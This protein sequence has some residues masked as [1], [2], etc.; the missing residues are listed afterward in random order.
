LGYTEPANG[1][2]LQDPTFEFVL[3]GRHA[4]R[5]DFR[6]LGS[7]KQIF[8]VNEQIPGRGSERLRSVQPYL[9]EIDLTMIKF[10]ALFAIRRNTR[11][12]A[13]LA[14]CVCRPPARGQAL[15][16]PNA[17]AAI[18]PSVI[19]FFLGPPRRAEAFSVGTPLAR[20][21]CSAVTTMPTTWQNIRNR[22]WHRSASAG[23][24]P[25]RSVATRTRSGRRG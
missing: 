6:L 8:G 10:V 16:H 2:D 25:L 9:C 17:H 24:V 12:C 13:P 20:A 18:L 14:Q 4:P 3:K 22:R 11:R 1:T 15:H 19:G 23:S 21:R 5:G 7:H